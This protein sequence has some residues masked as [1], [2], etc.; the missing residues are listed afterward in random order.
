V[1]QERVAALEDTCRAQSH[2][3]KR[4]HDDQEDP[5]GYEGENRRRIESSSA[6]AATSISKQSTVQPEAGSTPHHV[7]PQVKSIEPRGQNE[8]AMIALTSAEV[9]MDV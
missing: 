7:E 1:L 9:S 4:R 8:G 5:D 2:G 6:V 3:T